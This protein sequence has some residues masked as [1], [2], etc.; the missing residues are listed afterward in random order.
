VHGGRVVGVWEAKDAQLVLTL[1][2]DAPDDGLAGEVVRWA[3]YLGRDLDMR[4]ARA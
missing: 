2:S 4:I 1:W 3:K